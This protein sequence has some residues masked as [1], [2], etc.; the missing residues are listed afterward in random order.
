L[1]GASA[2]PASLGRTVYE[3]LLSGGFKGELFAVNPNHATILDHP[4]F[5]SLTA[6]GKPVDLA[7]IC[8]P[9]AAVPAILEEARGVARGAVILSGAPT[10]RAADFH[11]WRREIAVST[12]P[13]VRWTPLPAD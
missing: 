6:I 5:P 1:V 8:A 12:P 7:V 2:K 9:P 3:N 10:A 4:A 13:T 11:R